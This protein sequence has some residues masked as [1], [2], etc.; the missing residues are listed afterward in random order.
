MPVNFLTEDQRKR[1]APFSGEPSSERLSG[2]FY[3]DDRDRRIVNQH[4]GDHSR[5][6]LAAQFCAARFL[7]TFLE[8]LAEVPSGVS[9]I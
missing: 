4:R 3:L 7:G 9:N 5:L 8:D 2:Y 6:G 1:Y